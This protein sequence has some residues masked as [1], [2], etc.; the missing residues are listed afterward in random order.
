M[1]GILP[2]TR[3]GMTSLV[4]HRWLKKMLSLYFQNVIQFPGTRVDVI[5]VHTNNTSSLRRLCTKLI[6]TH[7][8]MR[9]YFPSIRRNSLK[10]V[11]SF[12]RFLDH[13]HSDTSHSVGHLWTRDRARRRDL[14]LN[15]HST[16]KG[17]KHPC[18][19]RDSNPQSQQASARR[20]SP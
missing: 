4:R 10:L 6:N 3:L 12:L 18:L 19:R 15:R 7:R 9:R 16:H 2:L 13:T 14:Y 11:A 5:Y 8:V 20:P 17:H 1:C